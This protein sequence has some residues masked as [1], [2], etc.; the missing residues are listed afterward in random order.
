[1][2][3]NYGIRLIRTKNEINRLEHYLE[4]ILDYYNIPDE[5]FGNVLLAVTESV[6]LSLSRWEEVSIEMK[7]SLRGIAFTISGEKGDGLRKDEI[8]RA[9]EQRAFE[10]EAFIIRSLADET[11]ISNN[12]AT[13]RLQF[14]ISGINLERALLRSKKLKGYLTGKE[15]VVDKNE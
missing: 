13:I 3:E 7:R 1:M 5:Y 2:R 11:E 12:E 4:E 6:S 10:R 8:D 15:K 14:Y 9:M